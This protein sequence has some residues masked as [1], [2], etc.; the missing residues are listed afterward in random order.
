LLLSAALNASDKVLIKMNVSEQNL[1][2]VKKLLPALHAPTVSS[3][4]D[5]GWYAVETVV[6]ESVVRE[7]IPE[8]K[9]AGAEGIIEIGLN[10][11]VA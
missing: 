10:K 11:V 8:L 7:I 2:K 9:A 5:T 1:S 4:S 6:N 3:L